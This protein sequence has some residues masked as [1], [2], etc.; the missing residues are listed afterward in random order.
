[1]LLLSC[2]GTFTRKFAIAIY[3]MSSCMQLTAKEMSEMKL[4]DRLRV[5]FYVLIIHCYCCCC[6]Y[7]A[8]N[9]GRTVR[10]KC[11]N[12]NKKNGK[13]KTQGVAVKKL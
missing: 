1:M 8:I 2:I 13:Q 10:S 6:C 5:S 3:Y 11:S 9:F 12:K 4:Q 7:Y